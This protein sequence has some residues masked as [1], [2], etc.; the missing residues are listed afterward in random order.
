MEADTV[1]EVEAHLRWLGLSSIQV[2]RSSL[3]V[4]LRRLNSLKWWISTMDRLIV[5]SQL[6]VMREA[7]LP[8]LQCLDILEGQH[9]WPIARRL[10]GIKD[11]LQTGMGP[12]EAFGTAGD[13]FDSSASSE[14][15][16]P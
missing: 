12:A 1:G 7:G 13:L 3:R 9:S 11:A 8:L 5:G 10:S 6:R 2:Q 4:H 16:Q 15:G 14:F